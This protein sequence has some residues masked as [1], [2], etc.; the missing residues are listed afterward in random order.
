MSFRK[1][2]ERRRPRQGARQARALVL[3]LALGFPWASTAGVASARLPD[4]VPGALRV[5]PVLLSV[6][7]NELPAVPSAPAT[8]EP[9]PA[10]T[11][12][13]IE[14]PNGSHIRFGLLWQAQL[15]A[16]GNPANDDLSKN[17]FLRRFALL[18]GGTVLHDIDYFFDTDFGDLFK[19]SGPDSLKNGPELVTKDAFVTYRALGDLLKID[20][21]LML[22]PG[23]RNSL[24]G[25][26][27]LL[28]IDF[29]RNTF[30]HN[31]VFG[32][33][34]NPF[35]R[36]LGVQLRGLLAG[37]LLEYRLGA[38]QGR[39]SPPIEG[40]SPRAPARNSFRF[41]G[42]LQLDLL[43]SESTFFY[44]GTYLGKKKILALGASADYQHEDS[45]PYVAYAADAALDLPLG[46]GGVTAELDVVRRDGGN[47]VALPEQTAFG[48]EAGYR[49][50]ALKLS[51]ILRYER[52]WMDAAPGDETDLGAGL[53]FWAY[54]HTS[55]LKGLYQYTT[56]GGSGLTY[57][58]VNLQWQLAFY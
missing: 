34:E 17:F 19:A 31:T 16:M 7:A 11:Q 44:A 2:L 6:P 12:L 27:G 22:P 5:Q 20:A 47:L 36:D 48:A 52:R 42:R 32:S 4:P 9:P 56:M 30:R 33:T 35:G 24:L 3:T 10:P 23:A 43:D 39:R 29:F 57:H 1:H 50:D 13:K 28:G 45:A 15:E 55:N 8:A 18:I 37:G 49:I 58:Q 41:A 26:G 51:P 46:P 21:G 54:G 38:F 14:L 25:G 40:L 53:A